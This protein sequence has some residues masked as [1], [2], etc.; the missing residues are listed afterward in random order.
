MQKTVPILSISGLDIIAEYKNNMIQLRA[1]GTL[2]GLCSPLI[3]RIN[4]RLSEEKPARIDDEAVIISTWLPPIPSGAFKRLIAAEVSILL[5][6]YVPETVSFEIT[7]ECGCDCEHCVVSGGEGELD[8]EIIK[9][10]ID[11]A[12]DMG[13]FIITFTEGDPM[14]REDILDLVRYVDKERAIVN[15]F[16]PGFEVTPEKALELKEAGLHNLLVSIYSPDPEKHDN[17]RR[18]SG[19]HQ[20]AVEAIKNGLDAGLLVTMA[21]HISPDRMKELDSLYDFATELGVHEF[22]AWESVPKKA[23]DAILTDADRQTIVDMYHRI[24]STPGGVRMFSN[25]YFEGEMLGCMAGRRW[26]HICVDGETKPCPYMPFSFGNIQ[27]APLQELW[28]NIRSTKM[29]KKDFNNGCM[30]HDASFQNLMAQ[31]PEGTKLPVR[32]NE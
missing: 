10:A 27:D 6:K 28:K 13:A 5:G 30:M 16:T 24:N 2:G 29:F 17:V 22:S 15:I 19:A 11:D 14:L 26:L 7:R 23:G 31:I 9:K 32:F 21:T 20:K 12:L 3:T 25:T 8:T 18:T 1:D 4:A